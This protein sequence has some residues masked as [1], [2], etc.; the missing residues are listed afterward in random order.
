MVDNDSQDN[1]AATLKALSYPGY[2]F[3]VS[4]QNLG[5]AGGNNLGFKQ[6]TGQY[7]FFLNSDA[8]VQKGALEALLIFLNPPMQTGRN[9]PY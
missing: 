3:V 6:A 5:F 2:K 1:S 7:V 8:I 4:R 9:T